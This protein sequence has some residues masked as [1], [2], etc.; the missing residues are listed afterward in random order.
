MPNCESISQIASFVL[1]RPLLEVSN[2]QPIEAGLW[3]GAVTISSNA[4]KWTEAM[5]DVYNNTVAGWFIRA[6]FVFA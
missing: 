4:K 3:T 1:G 5:N 6:V 2:G